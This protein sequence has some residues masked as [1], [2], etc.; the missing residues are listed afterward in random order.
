MI[1]IQN[2]SFQGIIDA[3]LNYGRSSLY[4]EIHNFSHSFE[5]GKSYLIHDSV[6]HAG[7]ALS[8][9][10]GGAEQPQ[11]GDILMNGEVYTQP[12]RRHH[13]WLIRHDEIKRLGFFRMSIKDQ[14]QR[15]LRRSNPD[16]LSL[17]KL[18]QMF[19]LTPQRLTRDINRISSEAWRASCAIGLAHGKR[20][21]CFPHLGHIRPTLIDE[22]RHLWFEEHIHHLR[23]FGCLILIPATVTD[24]SIAIGDEIVNL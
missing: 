11:T 4:Q 15:G 20:V 12:L 6:S 9:I 13:S 14:I 16:H 3:S 18:K 5:F 23:N 17:E 19:R 1:K 7:W 21:F 22:Y 10:L 2:M 8:W 24:N